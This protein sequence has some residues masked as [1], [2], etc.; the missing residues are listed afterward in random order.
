MARSLKGKDGEDG[1]DGEDGRMGKWSVFDVSL[2]NINIMR[3]IGSFWLGY[4]P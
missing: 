1:E 3:I 4:V 2:A